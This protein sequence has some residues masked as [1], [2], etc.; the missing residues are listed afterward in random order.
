MYRTR[1]ALTQGQYSSNQVLKYLSTIIIG[2]SSIVIQSGGR[3]R[4]GCGGDGAQ[5]TE[6]G[7]LGCYLPD[8][9]PPK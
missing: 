9:M 3:A 2:L 8:E 1:N 7:R 5:G 4:A 6:G